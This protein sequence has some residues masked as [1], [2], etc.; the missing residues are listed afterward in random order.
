MKTALIWIWRFFTAPT[1]AQITS[2]PRL[3]TSVE[4]EAISMMEAPIRSKYD[5]KIWNDGSSWDS[6]GVLDTSWEDHS[7]PGGNG[8]QY[9]L[10]VVAI[11]CLVALILWLGGE[12]PE[13]EDE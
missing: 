9:A 5:T 7:F 6:I 8:D 2:K 1:E 10:C 12:P 3:T 4:L 11:C 13:N